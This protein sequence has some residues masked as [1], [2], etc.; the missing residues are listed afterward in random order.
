MNNFFNP[1][2]NEIREMLAHEE[3][4]C[5]LA[6]HFSQ[7]GDLP[8]TFIFTNSRHLEAWSQFIC[9]Y[10]NALPQHLDAF[11]ELSHNAG[12]EGYTLTFMRLITTY[13]LT[14]PDMLEDYG[15][16]QGTFYKC[17]LCHRLLEEINDQIANITGVP[18]VPTNMSMAN[19]ACYTLIGD[20]LA[21][22]LD[23]LVLLSV[24][25][26]EVDKTVLSSE[27]TKLFMEKRKKEGWLEVQEKWPCFSQE[28][29]LKLP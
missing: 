9:A 21:M 10:L 14:P 13:F 1:I 6:R 24:E 29:E 2:N 5:E 19:V 18:L 15:Q 23:H 22:A 12:I 26:T 11:Y 16:S 28:F 7:H 4:T 20:E 25:T 8:D 3:Q 27:K 17:Y